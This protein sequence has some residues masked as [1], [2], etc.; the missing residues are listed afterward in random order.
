MRFLP[1]LSSKLIFSSIILALSTSLTFAQGKVTPLP[2]PVP[3]PKPVNPIRPIR[4]IEPV[5]PIQPGIIMRVPEASKDSI[6][7]SELSVNVSVVG[8]VATTTCDMIFT[9]SSSRVL[10]GEFEFPLG[11][12]QTIVGYALD[13]NG[14][15]RQGV[16]VE[17]EK[18]R[19][20]FEDIERRNVDPGLVE[21]TA[22][23]NFKTRVYP[24]PAHG[25]RHVQ[26]SYEETVKSDQN[27]RSYILQPICDTKLDSFSFEITVYSM[28]KAAL[29][30]TK[31]EQFSSF[32][33]E[34]WN[35]GYHNQFSAKDYTFTSPVQVALPE[36]TDDGSK[37]VFTQDEGRD[38]YFYFYSPMQAST[39]AKS[40]PGSII[41][42]YD[43]S[44]S[45]E[46]RNF[47][48]EMELLESY[49][50]SCFKSNLKVRVGVVTFSNEIHDSKIF[51]MN[52]ARSYQ[53]PVLDEIKDYLKAQS[54]DGA[55]N[56]NIDFAGLYPA[57]EI[58]IFSDGISN[59]KDGSS[60]RDIKSN[61]TV[62]NTINSCSSAD[63]G[64]L[65]DIA[66]KN[67]GVYINLSSQS[68][69]EALA[70]LTTESL[71]LLRADY[72]KSAITDLL[73][74]VGSAITGDFS[75]AGILRKKESLVTL[76]FGYGNT[77]TDVKKISVSAISGKSGPKNISRL[78]AEKKIDELS[79]NYDANK[80]EILDLAKRFTI[81]TKDTSLIVLDSASD[82]AKYGIEPPD[83]LRAEYDKI[84]SRQ[85]QTKS[86]SD[87][88]KIPDSVYRNFETFKKW[89]NT[90]YKASKKAPAKGKS[91]STSADVYYESEE[92]VELAGAGFA[93]EAIVMEAAPMTLSAEAPRSVA[94]NSSPRAAASSRASTASV[95]ASE[96]ASDEMAKGMSDSRRS[97][98]PAG[99]ITLQAWDSKA[100]Y[101]ATLKKTET[102]RMYEKY[103]EL[104]K[105]NS[106]S[107]SFYMEVADYF[108][109][110]NLHDEALRILSNLA[111]M[112]LE[113]SDVLRAMG[114]K[115]V[116]WKRYELA[117]P[118]FE[119]LT[120]IRSEIPQ[121]Y[122]DLAIALYHSG[123]AQKAVDTLYYMG[124]KNWDSRFNEIQ[125]IALNDMNAIIATEKGID[126]S[127][128]DKKLVENFPVD[129][130][131]V[132]TWNT[133]NCDIDLWV[134]DP[135]GEKCYYGHKLTAIGGRISR[136][137]T[138]GYGPEE[139][140]IKSALK[141]K[142]KIEAN[143]YG[144]T[145][146]KILQPVVVQA[147]VY[148]N[149]GTPYQKKQVL[150]LQ[151]E[152][153]KGSFTVGTI[154]F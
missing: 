68:T 88:S 73:P 63:H 76:S 25:S 28:D 129:I 99:E 143:Y 81:V 116:E 142:Y 102:K 48:A 112:N 45:M 92:S 51:E 90:D 3:S 125:Q 21:L 47:D 40:L 2:E 75:M 104:K 37:Q 44:S 151:L 121:F 71:R 77:V 103:L 61:G 53:P 79:K 13:I 46:G 57:D 72:D 127:R 30:A 105:E 22:G 86:T 1:K 42:Y 56:F 144:T 7:L 74:A 54:Y 132:L 146:Q 8:N 109:E 85:S 111:E 50:R 153:V 120:K 96:A 141:G 82:Y 119:K 110:E 38:T 93:D 59:W 89:W 26:I 140:C 19:T 147:E 139:F 18:A 118:V 149:F 5:R 65:Q 49:I 114:N 33:L 135:N 58:L 9:N 24:L 130:R 113:N 133:D 150:T 145:S 34:Q 17:K 138:Q 35:N 154:E 152:K 32:N 52:A 83:E 84:V 122:R 91:R 101:I 136:D 108:M 62:I 67:G 29:P 14:K 98:N 69:D 41:V 106:A 6:K 12:G 31:K 128:M 27:G 137:F 134:T 15:M 78:W 80:S 148:T 39:K 10:E 131:I 43:V 95:R 70:S 107:P 60:E 23:N 64:F 123:Q 94:R 11:Q 124:T 20:V 100:K 115:L 97:V 55:T 16:S 66:Q 36:I 126:T 87:D 4:P 117:V